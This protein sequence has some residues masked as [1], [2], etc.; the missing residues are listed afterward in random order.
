VTTYLSTF[1]TGFND[2]AQL[3]LAKSL[4]DARIDLVLDGLIVYRTS[5][6]INQVRQLNF[7]NNT[8]IVFKQIKD[9]SNTTLNTIL[10]LATKTDIQPT[11][12]STL[13]HRPATFRVKTFKE[14]QPVAADKQ[15]I[16]TLESQLNQI[17]NFNLN[18]SN[19]QYE[20]WCFTRREGYAFYALKITRNENYE[21]TLPK[22]E[23]RPELAHLL[24]LLSEPK[25]TDV[26]LD[27]FAGHGSIPLARSKMIPAISIIAGD[28]NADLVNALKSKVKANKKLITTTQLDAVH[29]PFEPQSITK[30]VTDPPWGIF[31]KD[32]NIQQLYTDMLTEFCRILKPNGIAVILTAQKDL[33]I[34]TL[35]TQPS[36]QL[37]SEHTTLVSGKKASVY[38]LIKLP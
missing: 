7:L 15:L 30:I 25:S 11:I 34:E 38:K 12:S 28:N 35:K 20:F 23:L 31:E 22:G 4:K 19:S 3:A 33:F 36:L 26:F 18:K 14:N 29:T 13:P 24:C 2:I 10:T 9:S 37:L 6:G 16:S 5:A 27:P 32:L 8:F 1:I 17:P 21:R